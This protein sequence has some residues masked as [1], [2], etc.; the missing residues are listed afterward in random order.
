MTRRVLIVED[1]DSLLLLL[2]DILVMEGLECLTAATG[3]AAL[4]IAWKKCPELAIVDIGLPDISGWEVCRRLREDF[5]TS[6]IK[7]L[8]LSA[9]A[10]SRDTPLMRELGINHFVRKPYDPEKIGSLVKS[11]LE[12]HGIMGPNKRP[13]MGRP[14][15]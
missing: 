2:K 4:E 11:M 10:G 1:E 3:K 13:E 7:I 15:G 5:R 12:P 6:T 9:Q 8:V 14:L